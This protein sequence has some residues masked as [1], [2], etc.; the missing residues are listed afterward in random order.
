M[1]TGAKIKYS[2]SNRIRCHNHLR[3]GPFYCVNKT[4]KTQDL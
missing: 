1:F 4:L 3:T 2:N